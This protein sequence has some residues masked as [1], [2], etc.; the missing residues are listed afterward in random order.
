M[1]FDQGFGPIWENAIL[2]VNINLVQFRPLCLSRVAPAER[3]RA[4]LILHGLMPISR[5]IEGL[6]TD[7]YWTGTPSPTAWDEII[8]PTLL[9]SCEDDLF[10]TA[11][12]ARGLA[13]LIRHAS[14]TIWPSGGRIWLGHDD[15]V[16]DEI[17]RFVSP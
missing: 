12:T 2:H 10:G 15:D 11:D 13:D 16:A 9:L 14:L 4:R 6:K 8:V 1:G 5:K 17:A 7:A 3:R